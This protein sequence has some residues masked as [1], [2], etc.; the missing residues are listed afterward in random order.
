[1]AS[2]WISHIEEQTNSA[3]HISCNEKLRHRDRLGSEAGAEV[4]VSAVAATADRGN[5]RQLICFG[6]ESIYKDGIPSATDKEEE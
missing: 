2:H 5:E 6:T 1:V 4:H 3:R